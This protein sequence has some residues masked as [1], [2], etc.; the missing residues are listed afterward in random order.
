[1][2]QKVTV[3]ELKKL[4]AK[5]RDEREWAKYHTPKDLA[6]SISV[7]A[8]ELLELFQW[9]TNEEVEELLKKNEKYQK[10][11][12]ELAD[13]MI[14]CLNLAD[15]IGGDVSDAVKKKLEHNEKKYPIEKIKGNYR[16]YTEL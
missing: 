13:V 14:Y 3:E 8:N 11:L 6:V 16:K 10:V 4:V 1:M 7:E 2:D 5:F 12:E 15:T 9:K